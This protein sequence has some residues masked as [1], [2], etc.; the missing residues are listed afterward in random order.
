MGSSTG[1]T[2]NCVQGEKGA[3]Q[4]LTDLQPG[5]REQVL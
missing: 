2:P 3:A 5:A 4:L 1:E